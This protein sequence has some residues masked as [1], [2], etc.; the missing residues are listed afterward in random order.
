MLEHLCQT[1]RSEYIGPKRCGEIEE[2]TATFPHETPHEDLEYQYVEYL[3]YGSPICVDSLRIRCSPFMVKLK[4]EIVR[5]AIELKLIQV[6]DEAE[7]KWKVKEGESEAEEGE[8]TFM[9]LICLTDSS[10]TTNDEKSEGGTN[11]DLR[12]EENTVAEDE[13]ESIDLQEVEK[14]LDKKRTHVLT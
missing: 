7:L 14:A 3:P 9:G 1:N 6:P 8:E 12:K 2:L 5:N 13:L 4:Q 10:K 11:H